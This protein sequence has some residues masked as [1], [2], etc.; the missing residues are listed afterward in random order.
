MVGEKIKLSNDV[1]NMTIAANLS[2]TM[3]PIQFNFCLK[4]VFFCFFIQCFCCYFFMY[5]FIGFD[6]FQ[7][8][9]TNATSLRIICTLLMHRASHAK[10]NKAL[11]VLTYVKRVRGKHGKTKYMNI[12]IVSMQILVPIFCIITI[13][14]VMGQEQKLSLIIKDFVMLNFILQIDLMYGEVLPEEVQELVQEF[15]DEGGLI[16]PKDNNSYKKLIVRMYRNSNNLS[17][18]VSCL[19]D[20]LINAWYTFL[21]EFSVI[22]YNYFGGIAVLLV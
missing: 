1:Y 5:D 14:T 20:I 10:L 4:M 3:S 16:M 7:P 9:E 13:M 2:G 19:M 22:I 21:H 12:I 11:K 8:I 18:L 6:N 17:K 15:N